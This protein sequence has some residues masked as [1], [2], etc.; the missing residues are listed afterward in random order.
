MLYQ[1]D[2]GNPVV[3]K[4]SYS[5]TAALLEVRSDEKAQLRVEIFNIFKHCGLKMHFSK[6][7]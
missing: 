1:L 2:T 3:C 7:F 4:Q 6:D 5:D